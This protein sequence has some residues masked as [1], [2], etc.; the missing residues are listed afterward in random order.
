MD[1]MLERCAGIDVHQA[2]V[3]VTVRVPGPAGD[4]HE[5]TETFSTAT[6]SLLTMREWL[7]AHGVT[8]VAMESTGVYWKPVYYV[9]EDGCTL[10]LV[11]TQHVKR[12]P[13][14]KSDVRDSAW[15]AQLLECGLLRGSFVPPRPIR[16]LRDLTRYRKHQVRDR[17]REVNRL[18]RVLEDA[19][20][21]L[22]SVASNVLGASGRAMIE[23]LLHGTTDPGVL[24]DLAQG[25]LRRKLPALRQ[26]LT[27]RFRDHHAFLTGQILAKID[28][29]EETIATCSTR[30]AELL[31]PFQATLE[32]LMTI[33]GVKRL[34]A[35][36]VVA[37]TGGDMSR[38]PSDGHLCSWAAICPGQEESAGKRRTGQTRKGNRYLRAAL[39]ECALGASRAK[40]TALQALYGRVKSHRGHKKAVVAV[41]HQIL[42]I[43]YHL[44]RNETVYQ[45]LGADYF[46]RRHRQR[47]VRRHLRSLERLGYQV[48]LVEPAA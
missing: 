17:A 43:S 3:M 35:E 34:T 12:V 32:R 45:E 28:F 13:G 7:Q 19:G 24:A 6:D 5:I 40:H 42:R 8:H 38:F 33:P 48:L 2:T 21:K 37:E 9:L 23:A 11:N 26:A 10:L 4:R 14:R 22:S 46:D 39:I 29:L 18:H 16:E 20:I 1:R 41:A 31:R 36:V 30:I 27:G 44:M 15:L 25:K 47:T